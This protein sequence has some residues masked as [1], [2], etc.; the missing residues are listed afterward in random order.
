VTTFDYHLDVCSGEGIAGWVTHPTGI[1]AIRVLIRGRE[2]GVVTVG[3]PRE[4]VAAARPSV[5]GAAT[6]GFFVTFSAG[7]FDTREPCEIELEFRAEDQ[8]VLRVAKRVWAVQVPSRIEMPHDLPRAPFPADVVATLMELRP[9][10]YPTAGMW[11]RE[12]RELAIAD[13]ATILQYRASAKP[14]LRYAHYLHTMFSCFRFIQTHYERFNRFVDLSA[15]DSAAVASSPEEMLCIAN[16][17]YVL[18]S[19]GL[20]TSLVECGCFKGFSTCCLSQACAWLG[21]RLHVFDSFAG[22]PPVDH[23]HYQ[24]GDFRGSIDEVTDNLRTFGRID[25][26]E[27]HEGFFSETIPGFR[28]PFTCLW[29]DV[30]LQASATDVMQLVPALPAEACIFS[31]ECPEGAFVDGHP[32]LDASEVMP[33]MV[34][35]LLARGWKPEGAHLAGFLSALWSGETGIP[36]LVYDEVERMLRAAV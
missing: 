15:K 36:V 11:D 20:N 30:D 4:D 17:L 31:H 1:R 28:E 14:V 6:S 25:V 24:E 27:L 10:S 33:P 2:A 29:M 8:T 12:V 21:M 35:A 13:I 26:V 19:H 32:N 23:Y 9:G 22:L 34:D 16:H 3:V 5:P 18:K 7:T